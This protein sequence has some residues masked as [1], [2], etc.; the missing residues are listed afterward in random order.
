MAA[1]SKAQVLQDILDLLKKQP[2]SEAAPSKVPI[3]ES[4]L[5][6]LCREDAPADAA[7]EAMARLKG[8]FFDLNELRVTSLPEIQSK[9][10]GLPSPQ[11]RANRIRTFLKQV[12]K[13]IVERSDKTRLEHTLDILA[14]KPQKEATKALEKFEAF[15]SDF[16]MATVVQQSLGGHAIPVDRTALHCLERLGVAEVG[17]K[18]VAAARSA[19]ERAVPKNRGPKFIEF[20]D[21]LAREDCA[22][23]EPDCPICA[24]KSIDVTGGQSAKDGAA[25]KGAKAKGAAKPKPADAPK[26]PAPEP[27]PEAAPAPKAKGPARPSREKKS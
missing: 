7:R 10:K 19:L 5:Y 16:V 3:M 27:P 18:D 8:E 13:D 17:T 1:P 21:H 2:G 25:A 26:A 4:A 14:K 24:L 6:A 23:G 11:A 22:S 20:L 15:G 9:L 12:F